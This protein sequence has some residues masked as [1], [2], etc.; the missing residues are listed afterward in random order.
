MLE[1]NNDNL[2]EII[3]NNKSVIV[4]YGAAWCGACR[5]VKPQFA[6]LAE[7]KDGVTFVYV[8]A[9]KYPESRGLAKVDNLPTFAGFLDGQLIGQ[10]TGTNLQ[11]IRGL[12]D[13]IASN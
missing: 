3:Q 12:I 7:E 1:L 6:G 8:D 13:E 11:K 10:A 2:N 4:Q 5:V 9:E